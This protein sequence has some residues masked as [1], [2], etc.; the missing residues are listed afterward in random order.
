VAAELVDVDDRGRLE[1]GLLADVDA[2]PGDPLS[3]ITTTEQSRFVM[4]KGQVHR[5]DAP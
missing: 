2:V 3:D 1:R 5:H 4:K